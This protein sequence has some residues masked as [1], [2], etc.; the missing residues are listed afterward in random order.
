MK[1]LYYYYF[2]SFSLFIRSD[3]ALSAVAQQLDISKSDILDRES[4]DSL[5]VRTAAGETE[6]IQQTKQFLSQHGV[7]LNVFRGR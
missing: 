1:L 4:K 2:F 5:A 6:I 7:D 3:T